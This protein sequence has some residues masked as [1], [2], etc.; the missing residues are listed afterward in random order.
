MCFVRLKLK[1]YQASFLQMYI[2]KEYLD[3]IENTIKI[4]FSIRFI[5]LFVDNLE[6]KKQK[7]IERKKQGPTICNG[8]LED[9]DGMECKNIHTEI[10]INI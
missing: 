4:F 2:C 9:L 5:P 7:K 10:E 3:D 6:K 1:N 8:L